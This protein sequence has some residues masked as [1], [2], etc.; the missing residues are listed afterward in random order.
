[1]F[2]MTAEFRQ[3]STASRTASIFDVL[4]S[5]A[6]A[7]FGAAVASTASAC[8]DKVRTV[9]GRSEAKYAILL[10][11][12]M[13]P[14][15]G[16][17]R[18]VITDPV[19]PGVTQCGFYVD[20][21][22]KITLPVVPTADGNICMM[23]IDGIDTGTHIIVVTAISVDDPLWGSQESSPSS[24]LALGTT[25]TMTTTGLV[26][27]ARAAARFARS[28]ARWALIAALFAAIALGGVV[29]LR[30]R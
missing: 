27:A 10:L 30:R 3:S 2:A 22:T 9:E 15:T 26:H 6:G 28:K 17:T 1:M 13:A 8:R 23:N 11:A 7:A 29:W 25:A 5:S 16:E 18:S 20:S 4:I 24:P 12:L 21:A 14:L 19:V